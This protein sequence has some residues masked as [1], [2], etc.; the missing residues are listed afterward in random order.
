[1]H[2]SVSPHGYVFD[3]HRGHLDNPP[4]LGWTYSANELLNFIKIAEYFSKRGNMSLVNLTTTGGHINTAGSPNSILGISGYPAKSLE[5]IV[6]A[7]A[8]YLN[9]AWGRRQRGQALPPSNA[10]RDC[11]PSAITSKFF[12]GNSTIRASWRR[13]G[14]G[15]P[16]YPSNPEGQ[17][18]F[19]GLDGEYAAFMG[20]IEVAPTS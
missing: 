13:S 1:M 20:L 8:R 15:M 4:Q 16:A 17:G 7:H 6:W 18:S 10:I 9:D 5:F 3:Y 2:F 12:P 19:A 14:E 11:I